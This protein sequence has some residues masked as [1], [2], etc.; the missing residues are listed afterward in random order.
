MVSHFLLP[1][2]VWQK[3]HHTKRYGIKFFYPKSYPHF[4]YFQKWYN[5]RMQKTNDIFLSDLS[6]HRAGTFVPM[7]HDVRF[8]FVKI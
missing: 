7:H 1:H 6:V 3:L 8:D 4:A 5:I 2:L